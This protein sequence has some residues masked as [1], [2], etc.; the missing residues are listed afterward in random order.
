[1]PKLGKITVVV[2]EPLD[3]TQEVPTGDRKAFYQDLSNRTLAAIAKLEL[4]K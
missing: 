4:P 3:F 1:M 2:G